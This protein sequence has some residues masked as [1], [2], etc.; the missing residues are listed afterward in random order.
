MTKYLNRDGIEPKLIKVGKSGKLFEL[1]IS[2]LEEATKD[3]DSVEIIHDHHVK[4]LEGYSRQFDV[5]VKSI[6]QGF[7]IEIA[8]EC[9]EY[10][11]RKP[12][13]VELIESFQCKCQRVPTINRKVFVSKTGYSKGAAKAAKVFGIT[14]MNIET[15][16]FSDLLEIVKPLN[17]YLQKRYLRI[18]EVTTVDL[19]NFGII[20]SSYDDHF[21][22]FEDFGEQVSVRQL[23]VSYLLNLPLNDWNSWFVK[24]DDHAIARGCGYYIK[25]RIQMKISGPQ[26][27]GEQKWLSFIAQISEEIVELSREDETKQYKVLGSEKFKAEFIEMSGTSEDGEK[28]KAEL[29]LDPNKMTVTVNVNLIDNKLIICSE[30]DSFNLELLLKEDQDS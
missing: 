10:G 11:Q 2:H 6:I 30:T 4:N 27:N 18:V 19:E 15:L 3:Y 22:Q 8:I 7:L 14:L 29:I 25:P 17:F 12:V 26:V 23:C 1:L 24:T 21:I 20:L 5:F 28:V 16:K 13:G 9:K